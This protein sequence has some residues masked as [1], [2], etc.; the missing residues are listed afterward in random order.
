MANTT[1]IRHEVA[2]ALADLIAA[3]ADS[4]TSVSPYDPGERNLTGERIWV[5]TITGAVDYPIVAH[6]YL[7]H[8]DRFTISWIVWVYKTGRGV[9]PQAVA[10]RCQELMAAINE[11]VSENAALSDVDGVIDVTISGV[12]GPD[13]A[14]HAEGWAALATVSVEAHTRITRS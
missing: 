10:E 5:D 4:S 3:S 8:D 14:P 9:I 6:H 1:F 12:D 2:L 7:P 13:I 11:A